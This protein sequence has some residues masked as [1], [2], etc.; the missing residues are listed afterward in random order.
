MQGEGET[1]PADMSAQMIE[2]G[3]PED[4]DDQ[5]PE[6]NERLRLI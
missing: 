5:P 4:E 1:E 6:G 3:F 2:L